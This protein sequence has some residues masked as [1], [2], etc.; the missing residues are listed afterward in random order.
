[1]R[2]FFATTKHPKRMAKA[3]QREFDTRGFEFSLCSC[4]ELFARMSGYKNWHEL[5]TITAQCPLPSPWDAE[6]D[7]ET[8]NRRHDQYIAAM[9]NAGVDQTV[10]IEI[11]TNIARTVRQQKCNPAAPPTNRADS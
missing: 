11:V 8:V 6:I 9:I 10:A 2:I 7:Q 5:H 3:I 4:Q 1:M